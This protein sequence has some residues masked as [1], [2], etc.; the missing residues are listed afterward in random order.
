MLVTN[1]GIV[2][3]WLV[4]IVHL[5]DPWKLQSCLAI[6]GLRLIQ[7]A[8]GLANETHL[9][10]GKVASI[11]WHPGPNGPVNKRNL[12]TGENGELGVEKAAVG[13]LCGSPM[14]RVRY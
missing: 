12:S 13:N 8:P 9:H 6:A 10:L 3:F 4:A 2:I 7:A 5:S 11:T 14:R 1:V